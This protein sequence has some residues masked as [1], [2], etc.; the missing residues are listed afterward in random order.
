MLLDIVDYS[1]C[2]PK[3]TAFFLDAHSLMSNVTYTLVSFFPR[4]Q[5]CA[6]LKCVDRY[7]RESEMA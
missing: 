3:N 7:L 6:Q 4:L 5:Q 2:L 1:T